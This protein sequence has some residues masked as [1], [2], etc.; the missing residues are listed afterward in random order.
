VS[1]YAQEYVF[2]LP[3]LE[4]GQHK[5]CESVLCQLVT[6]CYV[7]LSFAQCTMYTTEDSANNVTI[8][9]GVFWDIKPQ[10]VLHMRHITSLLQS[11]AS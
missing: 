8:P 3:L 9:N 10:F 11:T 2:K 5:S 1:F 4:E 7:F 6:E